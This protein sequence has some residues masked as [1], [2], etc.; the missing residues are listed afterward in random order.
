MTNTLLIVDA[1]NLIRRIH[2]VSQTQHS[3]EQG[4]L[5]ATLHA[6]LNSVNKLLK[7]LPSSHVIAVFDGLEPSWRSDIW[8]EYK[9]GRTPAPTG[10][11]DY[12]GNIQDAL[13]EH[14]IESL[15]SEADEADDLIATLCQTLA[16]KGKQSIIVST[17]KGFFQLHN[18]LI[19]QFDYFN[20][21]W[22]NASDYCHK[23]GILPEQLID[24]WSLTGVSS[25]NIKGVPGIGPKSAAKLLSRYRDLEQ[26]L[27]ANESEDKLQQ[28]VR[29]HQQALLLSRDLIILKGD[30]PLGFNLKDIR[31]NKNINKNRIN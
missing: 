12:L 1:M 17:D 26:L 8:P 18:A 24:Y 13:L 4:Q 28:K 6:T 2:A 14:G 30:I 25:S 5:I 15:V 29:E 16:N 21:Q 23:V 7:Q 31:Y 3:T 10:L 9:A 11:I 22:L 20:Q 27:S 19:K